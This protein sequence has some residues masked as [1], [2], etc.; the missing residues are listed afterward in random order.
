MEYLNIIGHYKPSV[1]SAFD[2]VSK[3]LDIVAV[4]MMHNFFLPAQL[5]ELK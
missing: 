1:F 5:P 3:D 4:P 2:D